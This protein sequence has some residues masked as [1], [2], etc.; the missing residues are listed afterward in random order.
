MGKFTED[1][2]APPIDE[3][4]ATAGPGIDEGNTAEEPVEETTD[5]E[6]AI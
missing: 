4:P 1:V 2:P 6:A 5:P 3:T